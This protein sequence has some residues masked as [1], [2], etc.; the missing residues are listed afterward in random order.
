MRVL[1][2]KAK[3]AHSWKITIVTLSV[4]LLSLGY[5]AYQFKIENAQKIKFQYEQSVQLQLQQKLNKR[6]ELNKVISS[7]I[8]FMEVSHLYCSNDG[9]RGD[10]IQYSKKRIDHIDQIVNAAFSINQIFDD[11]IYKQIREFLILFDQNHEPCK[12]IDHVDLKLKELQGDINKSINAS[13][14][15]DSVSGRQSYSLE[16]CKLDIWSAPD[17]QFAN[18]IYWLLEPNSNIPKRIDPSPK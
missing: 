18:K 11:K 8:N 9:Y 14:N 1:D 6:D 4:S 7:A 13:I 10:K 2:E 16:K 5:T 12:D 3:I 17:T 15:I